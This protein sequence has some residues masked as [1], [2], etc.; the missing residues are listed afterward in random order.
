MRRVSRLGQ[1]TP[2]QEVCRAALRGLC[3]GSQALGTQGE[4]TKLSAENHTCCRNPADCDCDCPLCLRL[5]EDPMA[6]EGTLHVCV[7]H[8]DVPIPIGFIELHTR[9]WEARQ[10]VAALG[11]MS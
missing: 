10:S 11:E 1:D 6:R 3:A 8:E 5:A 7:V 2:V 9:A 4:V